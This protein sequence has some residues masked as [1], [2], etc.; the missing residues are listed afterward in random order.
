MNDAHPHSFIELITT[1]NDCIVHAEPYPHI[2]VENVFNDTFLRNCLSELRSELTAS[3]KETD[4]FKVFQTTDLANLDSQDN[5]TR[6]NVPNLIRLRKILESTEFRDFIST[7]TG[8]SS[9]DGAVDCSCN[10][11][12]T[13][14]HLLC[15]D[16]VISTRKVSYIIYL[17][18]PDDAWHAEDGGQLELYTISQADEQPNDSPSVSTLPVWNSMVAFEVLPGRSFHSVREVISETK[19]RV[20]ISGWFHTTQTSQVERTEGT[21]SSTLQQLQSKHFLA[22]E[23]LEYVLPSTS[24]STTMSEPF[25]L[26]KWIN[27]EYLTQEGIAQIRKVLEKEHSVQLF[28]FLL[29]S[30]KDLIRS[31][32]NREDHR[33]RRNRLNYDYGCGYGWVVKG[34]PHLCR[35]LAYEP[36]HCDENRNKAGDVLSNVA[37][38]L[39][40]SDE[41]NSWLSAVTNTD[42]NHMFSQVRRFR[43][44]LD[45]TLACNGNTSSRCSELDVNLCFT[46]GNTPQ[47]WLSG[48]LGAFRCFTST[49]FQDGPPDVY[50]EDPSSGPELQSIPPSF[51]TLSIINVNTRINDFVKYISARADVSRWDITSQFQLGKRTKRHSSTSWTLDQSID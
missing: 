9:L 46:S 39:I 17:S 5:K 34:P 32:L 2:V 38:S 33:N 7:A 45:Y 16:D 18:E 20:S 8:C 14:C 22:G 30:I 19:P 15:H 12:T 6:K 24:S 48:D 36:G 35:Y 28:S 43:P 40:Q 27:P 26:Q 41:F 49:E 37:S 1:L 4:L 3:Y 13:G 10:V 42:C 11:Y 44:G 23:K 29:P 47:Q 21:L 50:E 25:D 51:N 31:T